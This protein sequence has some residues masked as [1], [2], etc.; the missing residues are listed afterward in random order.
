MKPVQAMDI[1]VENE[2]S[3]DGLHQMNYYHFAMDGKSFS[4]IN[5]HFQDLLSK[6]ILNGTVFAR[7]APDQKTQ[8][9]EAFQNV[10]GVVGGS[11]QEASLPIFDLMPKDFMGSRV[12]VEDSQKNSLPALC[13]YVGMCGDGAN[14]CGA[15][16]MFLDKVAVRA[17]VVREP[18]VDLVAAVREPS[19]DLVAAVREPSTDLVVAV[20]EPSTDSSAPSPKLVAAAEPNMDMFQLQSLYLVVGLEVEVISALEWGMSWKLGP[21]FTDDLEM[22]LKAHPIEVPL[23]SDITFFTIYY[24]TSFGVIQLLVSV[25]SPMA[26]DITN[27]SAKGPA[28][29]ASLK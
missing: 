29:P 15:G 8:L 16:I 26:I 5:E 19:T 24:A 2:G 12:N 23:Y 3:G 4:V 11:Q 28:S 18:S 21:W 10:E 14:D 13:Y 1:K 17:V 20:R 22:K 9:V 6:L 25:T 7:M 27:I